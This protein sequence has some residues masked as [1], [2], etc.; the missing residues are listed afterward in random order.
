MREIIIEGKT[1]RMSNQ[2]GK[3]TIGPTLGGSLREQNTPTKEMSLAENFN[4]IEQIICSMPLGS[5]VVIMV[6]V[7]APESKAKVKE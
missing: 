5:N 1:S 2:P 3:F 6:A 4:L 7:E